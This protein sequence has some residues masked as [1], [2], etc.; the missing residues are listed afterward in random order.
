M[1]HCQASTAPSLNPR[2][3]RQA[4]QKSASDKATVSELYHA[5]GALLALGNTINS[6]TISAALQAAL[7]KDDSVLK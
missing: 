1:M 5:A 3:V 4:L 2:S 6:K 7:K